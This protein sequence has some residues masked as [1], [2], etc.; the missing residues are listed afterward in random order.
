MNDRSKYFATNHE[1]EYIRII[2]LK[3]KLNISLNDANLRLNSIIKWKIVYS[4]VINKDTSHK[5]CFTIFIKDVRDIKVIQI[6]INRKITSNKI[7]NFKL[8]IFLSIMCHVRHPLTNFK[9]H[10]CMSIV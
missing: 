4:G 1:S 8:F 5:S 7:I 9:C 6:C 2:D 3:L 10:V